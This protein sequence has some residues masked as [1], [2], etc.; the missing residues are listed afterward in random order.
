MSRYL[1]PIHTLGGGG[2]PPPPEV[3]DHFAPAF[4]VGN[5]LAGDP[6][7]AQVAPF[8]YIPD[9]GDGTG[10]ETAL[11]EAAGIA[12]SWVHIRRG[13]YTLKAG[14]LPLVI[15][16]STRVTGDGA[17]TI[18]VQRADDRRVFTMA[19]FSELSNLRVNYTAADPGATGT[20]MIDASG[21][22]LARIQHVLVI[23]SVG[24]ANL[25][26][27]LESI[28]SLGASCF[29]FDLFMT[30][31]DFLGQGPSQLALVLCGPTAANSRV[32]LCSLQGGD[33]SIRVG[34]AL[35][36]PIGCVVADNVINASL[37]VVG[38]IAGIYARG[39]T[40]VIHHNRILFG[41]TGI[42]H[43]G[44]LGSVHGNV[45]LGT[46][47]QAILL[48][49]ASSELVVTDNVLGSAGAPAV[50]VDTGTDNEVHSNF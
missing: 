19:S 5:E 40:H 9:P 22:T 10:I 37:G 39:L 3:T 27:S 29:A 18:L 43:D 34:T 38:Q 44:S 46:T 4:I 33:Y 45:F 21:A 32:S 1:P 20:A 17:G 49:T 16:A 2:G 25:D 28:V 47:V 35:A 15:P 30:G 6:A 41:D 8:R 23:G 50:V 14:V 24:A 36:A 31:I 12:G 11:T 13:T 48:D 7:V 42:L 26:E